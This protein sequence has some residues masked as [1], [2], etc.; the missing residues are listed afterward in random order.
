[1]EQPKTIPYPNYLE[2]AIAIDREHINTITLTQAHL[3]QFAEKLSLLLRNESTLGL[4]ELKTFSV[5]SESVNPNHQNYRF[6]TTS[7]IILSYEALISEHPAFDTEP[8]TKLS[9]EDII[10]AAKGVFTFGKSSHLVWELI[11][12]PH[13]IIPDIIHAHRSKTKRSGY[14]FDDMSDDRDNGE[15]DIYNV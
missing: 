7:P 14:F 9:D 12:D 5:S 13:L 10:R 3:L 4:S 2:K 1:M 11:R 8:L 6:D 15:D